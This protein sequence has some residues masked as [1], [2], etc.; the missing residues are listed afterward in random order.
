[1]TEC[2]GFMKSRKGP[3]K[4]HSSPEYVGVFKLVAPGSCVDQCPVSTCVILGCSN[5][6]DEYKASRLKGEGR[7]RENRVD[8]FEFVCGCVVWQEHFPAT[9]GFLSL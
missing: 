9:I 6:Y 4:F 3:V 2:V 7:Q 8:S 1:M 5:I